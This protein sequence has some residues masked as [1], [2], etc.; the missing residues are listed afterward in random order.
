LAPADTDPKVRALP[1][2]RDLATILGQF[3]LTIGVIAVLF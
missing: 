2:T 1:L 3:A